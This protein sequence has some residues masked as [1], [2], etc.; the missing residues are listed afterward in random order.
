M[1]VP[2]AVRSFMGISWAL[3]RYTRPRF[4]KNSR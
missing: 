1:A 2:R 4:E 3:R